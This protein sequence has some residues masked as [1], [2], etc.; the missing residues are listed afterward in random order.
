MLYRDKANK[1]VLEK[2]YRTEKGLNTI[3]RLRDD[4]TNFENALKTI[5]QI[6]QVD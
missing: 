4:R 2:M 5:L 1:P 6:M 3:T